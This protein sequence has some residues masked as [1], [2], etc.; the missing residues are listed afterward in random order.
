MSFETEKYKTN[1]DLVLT[2]LKEI[3]QKP[4]YGVFYIA[5]DTNQVIASL[6]VTFEFNFIENATFYWIQSLYVL[7]EY[8]K[9]GIFASMYKRIHSDA[10]TEGAKF[11]KLYV[12]ETNLTGIQVYKKLQMDPVQAVFYN[13]NFFEFDIKM[14]RSFLSERSK[15]TS[16][17]F[18]KLNQEEVSALN[19]EECNSMLNDCTDFE[20]IKLGLEATLKGDQACEIWV[21]KLAEEEEGGSTEH[22][23]K[24]VVAILSTY[25]EVDDW[26][27]KMMYAVNELLVI[28]KY[29]EETLYTM[30]E[31]V[32]AQYLSLTVL[33]EPSEIRVRFDPNK[34]KITS[35]PES[36]KLS[37]MSYLF[38]E[39][40]VN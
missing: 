24:K 27:N 7:P 30:T 3:L 5:L 10:K 38:Y 21:L 6:L 13:I 28:G 26:N 2:S 29:D 4:E 35:I 25:F 1:T 22:A 19:F 11:V 12:A 17:T 9:R 40:P 34:K 33:K 36:L 23:S 15:S 31:Q 37:R 16:Y 32:L 18:T 39:K 8:R 14:F 20:R